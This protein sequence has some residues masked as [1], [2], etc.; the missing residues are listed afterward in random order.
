[1]LDQKPPPNISIKQ[2]KYFA[3]KSHPNSNVPLYKTF[4]NHF[5]QLYV[6]HKVGIKKPH[7]TLYEM[8]LN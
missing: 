8:V 5:D 6:S 1:M 2:Y 7:R 4:E 3:H